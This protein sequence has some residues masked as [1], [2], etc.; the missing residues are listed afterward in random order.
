ME[1]IK[2]LCTDYEWN[3]ETVHIKKCTF[4][5]EINKTSFVFNVIHL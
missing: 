5:P 4:A 3:K 2:N 1:K